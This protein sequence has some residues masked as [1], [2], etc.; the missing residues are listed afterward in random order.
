MEGPNL[1]QLSITV[2]R[3]AALYL[4]SL[5]SSGEGICSTVRKVKCFL[6]LMTA[7]NPEDICDLSG[8]VAGIKIL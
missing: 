8:L 2:Q 3:G 4:Y 5:S 7:M 6:K 1:L